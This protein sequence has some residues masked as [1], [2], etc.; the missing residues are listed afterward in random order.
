MTAEQPTMDDETKEKE[1]GET[2]LSKKPAYVLAAEAE[3]QAEEEKRATAEKAAFVAAA[4]PRKKKG[5]PEE[6]ADVTGSK[7]GLRTMGANPDPLQNLGQDDDFTI[8]LT[9]KGWIKCRDGTMIRDDGNSIYIPGKKFSLAQMEMAAQL[10]AEKGWTNVYVYQKNGKALH[11]EGTSMLASVLAAS[12]LPIQC[13]T[14]QQVAG[15]FHSHLKGAED[16]MR[17]TQLCRHEEARKAAAPPPPPA[18]P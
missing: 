13:C 7:T 17:H 14:S 12:G 9:G 16:A 2:R 5:E 6:G 4:N 18:A 3:E 8:D 1:T 15:K 10:S 11:P